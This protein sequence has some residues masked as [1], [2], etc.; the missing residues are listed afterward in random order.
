LLRQGDLPRPLHRR[1]VR[2]GHPHNVGIRNK[3]K[4]QV[5]LGLKALAEGEGLEPTEAC[6]STVFKVAQVSP[7][8]EVLK[9]DV[10][11]RPSHIELLNAPLVILYVVF[12]QFRRLRLFRC[13][14]VA[15]FAVAPP[16]T[17]ASSAK[18]REPLRSVPQNG[19]RMT[20]AASTRFLTRPTR[21][22]ASVSPNLGCQGRDGSLL[23]KSAAVGL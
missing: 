21:N 15:I 18:N 16:T 13:H 1:P 14:F 22:C 2:G 6:T 17:K 4:G 9:V 19:T 7:H 5:N 11:Q 3:G 8:I 20:L 10:L 12:V 23:G